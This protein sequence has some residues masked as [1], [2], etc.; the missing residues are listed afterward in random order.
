MRIL[1]TTRREIEEQLVKMG[2]YVKMEYLL[3]CLKK[4]IDF[5][6]RKFVL[7]KLSGLYESKSMLWDAGKMMR[8]AAEINTTF[9]SKINDFVK[10]AE[11]FVRG[12]RYDEADISIKRAIAIADSK[13]KIKIKESEK[14]FYKMMA[15]FYISNDKRKQAMEVYERMLALELFGEEKI[16]AQKNLLG[17]Y[18]KLGK[19][20]EYNTLRGV[21][22][23]G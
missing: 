1:G 19:I 14:E 11:L 8:N 17:L 18:E 6:A 23:K 22:S 21:M 4:D 9:Q 13:Q 7:V 15:R 3:S 16:E 12:G 2:D 10:S 20:R 5:E